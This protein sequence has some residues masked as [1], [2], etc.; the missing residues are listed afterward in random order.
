V[1]PPPQRFTSIPIW[2][3]PQFWSWLLQGLAVVL[4]LSSLVFLGF[5]LVTNLNRLGLSINFNDFKNQA[6]FEINE[7]L[8]PFNPQSDSY[9]R[10]F[11]VGLLNT[12]RVIVAGIIPATILGFL[13]GI[14]GLSDNWLL[15][16]LSAVY[17][18]LLRNLPLLIILYFFYLAGFLSLPKGEGI[19]LLGITFSNSGINFWGVLPISSEFGALLLGLTLYTSSFIAE[20]VRSGI[21]SVAKG[22]WE[23]ARALGLKPIPTLRLVILPQAFR[24]IVPS[25]GNEYLK[26]AK[27]SSLALA[28]GY[29]DLY[30]V[31]ST[32]YNQTGRAV[33]MMLLIMAS[34]L[35]ISLTIA[36]LLNLYNRRVQLPGR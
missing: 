13:V 26:L 19:N 6:G 29:Q 4:I 31:A 21:Q 15:R 10:A 27:N 24:A 9:W 2:R 36:L 7:K 16:Q 22:Q 33:E 1:T 32:T 23:A 5:N 30:S 25:L 20:I 28:V 8:I 18:Q 34:Y 12:L 35:L 14:G 17:T 11:L 3:R